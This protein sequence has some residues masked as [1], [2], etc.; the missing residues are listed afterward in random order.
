MTFQARHA[1]DKVRRCDLII[2][3]GLAVYHRKEVV[4]VSDVQTHGRQPCDDVRILDHSLEL[5][6]IQDT[7]AVLVGG[8]EEQGHLLG[9]CLD[10]PLLLVDHDGVVSRSHL[11]C[12]LE[13]HAR[14]HHHH[15][16]TDDELVDQCKNHIPLADFLG[17]R[18]T[19]GD[20][21]GQ[22]DLE[23]G[24]DRLAKR[25]EIL[26]ELVAILLGYR[27]IEEVALEQSVEQECDQHLDYKH[28]HG[29]PHQRL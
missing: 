1:P 7:V 28:Q 27:R 25:A 17:E 12:L 3:L 19:D 18:A 10:L 21:I 15:C 8:L 11:E 6:T 13:E 2:T 26:E 24:Q 29:E 16:E 14:D 4:R 23:H 22:S 9:V 20:P 5:V